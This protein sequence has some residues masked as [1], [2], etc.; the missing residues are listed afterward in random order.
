MILGNPLEYLN[1]QLWQRA[2]AA[3]AAA[4]SQTERSPASLLFSREEAWIVEER[5]T[6]NSCGKAVSAGLS[7][8]DVWTFTAALCGHEAAANVSLNRFL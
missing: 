3:P 1:T 8:R 6:R 2:C 5:G 7:L 4:R